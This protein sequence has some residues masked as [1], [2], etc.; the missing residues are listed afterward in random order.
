MF[1]ATRAPPTGGSEGPTPVRAA[2]PWYPSHSEEIAGEGLAVV[3]SDGDAD[4]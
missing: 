3:P 2:P 4:A 1:Q